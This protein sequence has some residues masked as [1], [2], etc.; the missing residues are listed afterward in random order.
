MQKAILFLVT[1]SLALATYAQPTKS[2]M[3]SVDIAQRGLLVVVNLASESAP[4]HSLKKMI[5]INEERNALN[6]ILA[7]TR[8][9]YGKV[10]V[11]FREET[12]EANFLQSL[13]HLTDD[14]EI[15]AVDLILYAHGHTADPKYKEGG[16]AIGLY[17]ADHK[18]SRT[19]ALAIKVKS[20][21]NK[22]LRMLYSDACWGSQQN[23]DWLDAGFLAVA[24]ST[25]VDGNH[26]LDLK[27]FL[28]KWLHGQS[29]GYSI[30]FANQS[31]AGKM[32]DRILHADSTKIPAGFL[33]ISIDG[34]ID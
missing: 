18:F 26:T 30:E 16:P 27:R 32:L 8:Q 6:M 4:R 11:L 17:S 7:R 28:K 12:N 23:Q 15:Q 19:D 34:M 21:S 13:N 14:P 24:G 20:L 5:Y 2:T 1:C 3:H 31:I 10:I 33:D 25:L 9:D 29:F 22:K